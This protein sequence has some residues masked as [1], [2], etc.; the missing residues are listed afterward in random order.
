MIVIQP[1]QLFCQESC[2]PQRNVWICRGGVL[3]TVAPSPDTLVEP[4]TCNDRLVN[5]WPVRSY[6]LLLG[7]E[8]C[9]R[10]LG[11]R[12][13]VTSMERKTNAASWRSLFFLQNTLKIFTCAVSWEWQSHLSW[14]VCWGTASEPNA[15]KRKKYF[16][17]EHPCKQCILRTGLFNYER[18]NQSKNVLGNELCINTWLCINMNWVP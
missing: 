7:Q 10:I 5:I 2:H 11:M 8:E 15:K 9:P 12:S 13:G 18:W 14:S 17:F 3:Y 16:N 1:F 6:F 4:A